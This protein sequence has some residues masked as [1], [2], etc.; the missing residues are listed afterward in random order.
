MPIPTLLA[1]KAAHTLSPCTEHGGDLSRLPLHGVLEAATWTA[2]T[3]RPNAIASP[4]EVTT[5]MDER[6][7]GP[8][9]IS[10][11]VITAS[12]GITALYW[13]PIISQ[14]LCWEHHKY[15]LNH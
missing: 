3:G 6:Q 12:V 2:V 15:D 11:V 10:L 1:R 14:T 9:P 8:G 4:Q 13:A 7:S 5:E